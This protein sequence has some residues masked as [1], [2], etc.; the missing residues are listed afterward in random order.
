[1]FY[2]VHLSRDGN[3]LTWRMSTALRIGLI[4]S[5]CLVLAA[6]TLSLIEG[7][8]TSL[9]GKITSLLI[10]V[11]LTMGCIYDERI[12]FNRITGTIEERSGLFPI[13]RR[14]KWKVEDLQGIEYRII[15]IGHKRETEVEGRNSL[16]GFRTRVVMGFHLGNRLYLLD[17]ATPIARATTWLKA[18]QAFW[19]HPVE[20]RK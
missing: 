13:Q 5:L 4:C 6:S 17:R 14:R 2:S 1:M 3:T 11:L 19:P 9:R 20:I 18:F 16:A 12:I 8:E 15:R 7:Q 10:T